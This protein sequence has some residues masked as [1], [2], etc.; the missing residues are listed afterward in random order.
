MHSFL[1]SKM[2]FSVGD[3]IT[4][5]LTAQT[6]FHTFTLD[7]LG[8]DVPVDGGKTVRHT[9]TFNQAGTFNLICIPH[10]MQGM[11]GTITVK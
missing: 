6:E 9:F 10:E 8:I 4:F 2:T 7:D 1:P 11:V 3:S 5:V